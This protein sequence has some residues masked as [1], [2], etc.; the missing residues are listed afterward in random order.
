MSLRSRHTGARAP[1]TLHWSVWGSYRMIDREGDLWLMPDGPRVKTYDP[2]DEPSLPSELARVNRPWGRREYR[3]TLKAA[4]R[5][6]IPVGTALDQQRVRALSSFMKA[7]GGLGQTVL[8]GKPIRIVEDNKP[9]LADG[10]G[11][12]WS[13]LHAENIDCCLWLAGILR[14]IEEPGPHTKTA[15][16]KLRKFFERWGGTQPTESSHLIAMVAPPWFETITVECPPAKASIGQVAEA[17]QELLA[18]LITPNLAG[19]QRIYD[20]KRSRF[21][22]RAL[23]QLIYWRLADMAGS[24]SLRQCEECST[25]FFCS[26][27]RQRFCPPPAGIRESRCAK[28]QRMRQLRGPGPRGRG[29][30]GEER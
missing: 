11:L 22:F 25:Y 14:N 1:Y 24:S 5:Q 12:T 17:A 15:S 2:A 7:F 26:D 9:F 29:S 21:E 18:G 19:V 27:P 8:A 23:I 16:E 30:P 28:R 10:D 20:G 13:L 3:Q 6:K 4:R